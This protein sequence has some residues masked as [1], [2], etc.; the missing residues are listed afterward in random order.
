MQAAV[1]TPTAHSTV[2]RMRIGKKRAATAQCRYRAERNYALPVLFS[3]CGA[4]ACMA[5]QYQYGCCMLLS[6]KNSRELGARIE[7]GF[8]ARYSRGF[9]EITLLLGLG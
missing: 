9:P 8:L 5:Q 2:R 6:V 4:S 7:A 1:P 3:V